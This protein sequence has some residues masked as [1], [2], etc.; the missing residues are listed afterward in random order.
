MTKIEP[1]P[2]IRLELDSIGW[3]VENVRILK[4]ISLHVHQGEM[5]GLLGPNGSG[6][7][8]LLR[9]IY[10]YLQPT[11]GVILINDTDITGISLRE[12]AQQIAAVLQERPPDFRIKVFE[13]VLMGRTP[14]KEIFTTDNENDY[15]LAA[16]A[17]E[18]VNLT[19]YGGRSLHTLSGGEI[20]R[21]Y[22]ARAL[23]QQAQLLILDEPTNHL[24][25]SHQLSIMGKIK[26]L[27]L[28]TITAL[29]DLNIAAS[30]CDRICL[31]C[32][33]EIVA[34]GSPE[35]VLSEKRI[36]EVYGVRAK[37]QKLKETGQLNISYLV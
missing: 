24:D 9:C 12:S 13:T 3:N 25:I 16:Q 14:H 15:N 34:I 30:F 8:S 27:S 19:G 4:D 5:V 32:R 35:S 11:S 26:E 31:L 1:P 21:V 37:V 2:S 28:S 6:K 17:L 18:D 22:L 29:H 7:S 23:C 36:G 20:Q 33:G 10:R